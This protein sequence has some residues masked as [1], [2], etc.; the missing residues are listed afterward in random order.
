MASTGE[1]GC[2]GDSLNDAFLKAM[3]SVGYRI[4]QKKILLSTG[5]LEEKLSFLDSARKLAEMSYT[6]Y[7]SHGTAKFLEAKGIPACDI[8]WP[9]EG[10]TPNIA[11]IIQNRSVELIINIPKNNLE[12]E[13]KN[14]SIIRKMAIDFDI[15]LIT[16]IKVAR[17]FVDALVQYKKQGLEIKSWE[18]YSNK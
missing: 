4:P 3:L 15:P 18:E 13:L 12:H 9:L 8:A 17:Q 5:S 2:I 10:K 16:N 7:A 1:V 14:N 6:L 11:D